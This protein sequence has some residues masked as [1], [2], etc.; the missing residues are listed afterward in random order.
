M[1]KVCIHNVRSAPSMGGGSCGS[2]QHR[3]RCDRGGRADA[4]LHRED[5]RGQYGRTVAA[6]PGGGLPKGMLAGGPNIDGITAAPAADIVAQC[7]GEVPYAEIATSA[8]IAGLLAGVELRR[9]NHQRVDSGK[10]RCRHRFD[11]DP[12]AKKVAYTSPQVDCQMVI[13]TALAEGWPAR[14]RFFRWRPGRPDRA[15]AGRGQPHR[16]TSG[17][18]H[19]PDKYK[20]LFY[21]HQYYPRF[22]AGGGDDQ[23]NCRQNP[24]TLRKILDVHRRAVEFVYGNREETAR[25]YAR[26]GGELAG[27]RHPPEILRMAALEPR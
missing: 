9:A 23:G 22:T 15:G 5:H 26:S 1:Y 10:A 21:G 19:H 25:I 18:D 4:R 16:S 7:A 2:T 20:V 13:R 12:S 11:Q 17:A 8:A 24:Q 27:E 6:L 3:E 14:W